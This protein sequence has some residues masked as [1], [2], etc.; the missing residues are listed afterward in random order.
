MPRIGF[1]GD[2]A[3]Q[4]TPSLGGPSIVGSRPNTP[5][6]Q[7][8]GALNVG[9]N[10]TFTAA[11]L[12][13]GLTL[14]ASTGIISGTTPAAGT[15]NVAITAAG[16]P[17]TAQGT[18]S[19]VSGNTLALTPPMGWDSWSSTYQTAPTAAIVE[20]EANAMVA[21]GMRDLGYQYVIIDGDWALNTRD[22]VT[23]QLV[24]NPSQFPNGIQ[25]VANYVHSLG[26]K[27]G[28]YTD[29]GPQQ[30]GVGAGS[31]GYEALDAQTFANWGPDYVKEDFNAYYS[32]GWSDT[33]PNVAANTAT[34]QEPLYENG[35]RPG[36]LRPVD[37]P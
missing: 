9:A 10:K 27:L 1:A 28:V 3:A 17:G 30:F 24:A 21:T 4:V 11:N 23:H 35:L 34:A 7:A 26:L 37:Y 25:A 36:K 31:Y 19:I 20:A 15:Y 12:P 16:S 5:F 13:A 29:T 18:L 32:F 8:V 33:G 14:N 2:L 22:P 6:L